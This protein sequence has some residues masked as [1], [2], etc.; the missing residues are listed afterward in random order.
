MSWPYIQIIWWNICSPFKTFHM[1]FH[2]RHSPAA[3]D[4]T[5]AA[6]LV[7][8]TSPQLRPAEGSTSKSQDPK[9]RVPQYPSVQDII[10]TIQGSH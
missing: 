7:Q 10:D 2:S 8:S 5:A 9:I 4:W 3:D 1:I 6:L